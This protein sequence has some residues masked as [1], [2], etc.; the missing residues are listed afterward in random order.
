M[1]LDSPF[2]RSSNDAEKPAGDLERLLM[3][4]LQARILRYMLAQLRVP[5][6]HPISAGFDLDSVMV[7]IPRPGWV[8][9]ASS[10]SDASICSSNPPLPKPP[11]SSVT[12]ASVKL[13]SVHTVDSDNWS[14]GLV[15]RKSLLHEENNNADIATVKD[16]NFVFIVSLFFYGL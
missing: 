5:L 9:E 13:G 7:V 4:M 15:L 6:T 11:Y 12:N 3:A 14:R 16:K 1:N 8:N 10:V 2:R